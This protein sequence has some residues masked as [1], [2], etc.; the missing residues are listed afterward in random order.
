MLAWRNCKAIARVGGV[1]FNLQDMTRKPVF[2]KNY[3]YE[4]I[5]FLIETGVILFFLL[6]GVELRGK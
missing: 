6:S 2:N 5:I 4:N 1:V 3:F